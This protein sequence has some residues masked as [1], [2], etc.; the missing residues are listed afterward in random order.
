MTDDAQT[1]KTA[2]ALFKEGEHGP[3]ISGQW[4]DLN[5][6]LLLS[7][8]SLTQKVSESTVLFSHLTN[9]IWNVLTLLDRIYWTSILAGQNKLLEARWRYYTAVDI[10]HFHIELRAIMDYCARIIA[11]FYYGSVSLPEKSFDGLTKWMEKNSHRLEDGLPQIIGKTTWFSEIRAIRDSI[12]HQGGMTLV[13]EDP[14]HGILFQ[15]LKGRENQITL[16]EAL[17]YNENVVYFDR[18]A[19]LY[20]SKLLVFFNELAGAL[21]TRIGVTPHEGTMVQSPGVTT[22]RSWI[23]SLYSILTSSE[24]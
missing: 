2:L 5:S 17:M 22:A 18:Y 14:F 6:G 1:L 7:H 10:E 23:S 19:A 15:I 20:L 3:Y 24:R 9:D 11:N 12:I 13:F 16:H 8:N 4:F 21:S